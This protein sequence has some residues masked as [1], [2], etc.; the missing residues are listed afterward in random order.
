MNLKD[1]KQIHT[2]PFWA[3]FTELI[4]FNQ[5]RGNQKYRT[6]VRTVPST[7]D[8]YDRYQGK[9]AFEVI[10]SQGPILNPSGLT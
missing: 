10:I 4:Y 9:Y 1:T 6:K 5:Q 7:A 3:M 2:L 8:N